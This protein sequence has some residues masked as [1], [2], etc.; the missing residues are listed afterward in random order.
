MTPLE[1]D[2]QHMRDTAPAGI[3][4]EELALAEDQLREYHAYAQAQGLPPYCPPGER[5]H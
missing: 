5:L 3:P 4:A 1:Q 2:L